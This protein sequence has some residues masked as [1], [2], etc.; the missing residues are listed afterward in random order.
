M[1]EATRIV[2]QLTANA[3]KQYNDHVKANTGSRTYDERNLSTCLA[4]CKGQGLAP[5]LIRDID[6]TVAVRFEQVE[7]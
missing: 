4:A 5:Q 7:F 2:V 1:N 6:G 3:V